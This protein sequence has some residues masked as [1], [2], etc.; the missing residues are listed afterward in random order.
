M[1]NQAMLGVNVITLIITI[2]SMSKTVAQY[3]EL[4]LI[5]SPSDS[6]NECASNPCLNGGTCTDHILNYTCS[7]P[8]H[9]NGTN[10]E[11]G[12]YEPTAGVYIDNSISGVSL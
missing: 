8:V 12:K 2:S 11:I 5:F 1:T 7:C 6:I 9:M 4:L 3:L 10:C